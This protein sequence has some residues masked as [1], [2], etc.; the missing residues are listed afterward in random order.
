FSDLSN[1]GSNEQSWLPWGNAMKSLLISFTLV[2]VLT[3]AAAAIDLAGL[4]PVGPVASFTKSADGV[5]FKCADGSEVKVAVLAPDLIRVRASFKNTLPSRDHSWAIARTDWGTVPWDLSDKPDAII[6][7]TTELEV[8]VRRSPLL[9]EF[10]DA[11][12]HEL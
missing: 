3:G 5:L 6:I 1:S 12:S 2:L 8:T 11:R 4:E 7:A 9:V 10:R